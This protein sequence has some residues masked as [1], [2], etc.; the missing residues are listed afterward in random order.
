[1]L[2]LSSFR[3]AW[4]GELVCTGVSCFGVVLVTTLVGLL[5]HAVEL[6]DTNPASDV[7]Y[8]AIGCQWFRKVATMVGITAWCWAVCFTLMHAYGFLP[9]GFPAVLV[10]AYHRP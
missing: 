6:G 3:S 7:V 1:M 2:G 8:A 10:R 5:H 9:L 4:D